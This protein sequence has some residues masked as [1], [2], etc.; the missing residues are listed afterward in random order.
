MAKVFFSYSHD[1]ESYRDQLE[2]HL[3]LLRRQGM[4]ES[5]HDRRIL[6]GTDIDNAIS[7]Q[8]E[9]ADVILLLVSASFIDSN[10]CYSREMARALERHAKAEAVVIP[11]IVRSCDWHQSPFGKLLAVP[12]DGKAVALWPN[13][14]EAYTDIVKQVR[15]VVEQRISNKPAIASPHLL[16]KSAPNSTEQP[17]PRSSNLRLKKDFTDRDRDEFLQ[18]GFE[19][20][21]RFFNGSL[22]ELSVRNPEIEGVFRR[23]DANAFTAGVYKNGRKVS[24]CS[25]SLGELGRDGGIKFS[26]DA[27]ARGSSFNEMLSVAVDDQAIHFHPLGMS[28]RAG[29]SKLSHEGAAEFLWALLIDRLQ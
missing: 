10:Y 1:D 7:A 21:A 14:D 22:Q 3:S 26:W 27:S 11:V 25:V 15:A 18:E 9:A 2:K 19:Y 6:A 8:L 23:I 5:W 29:D 17:L 28:L 13:H 20:V 16:A 24:E 12:K 4:I